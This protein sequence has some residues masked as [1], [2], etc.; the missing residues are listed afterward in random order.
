MRLLDLFCGAG[1][2]AMGYYYAG[3][4]DI[5]GVDI[6][7]QP[8]YPF[9]F[10]RADA[11]T[12]PLEEF[13]FIHA[14]PPCQGYSIMRNLPWLRDKSYPMLIEPTLERLEALGTPYALENVMGA[15]R[16]LSDAGWLCGGMFDLPLYRHRLFATNWLWHAPIHPKHKFTVRNGR[17]LGSRARDIVH[18]GAKNF[19]A[20]Y[21][22]AA[23]VKDARQAMGLLYMTRDELTQA[24]PPAYTEYIG[25]Q[26]LS[27][28]ASST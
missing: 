1:G 8:H 21:G 19:G 23:G 28:L 14:S 10:I 17:K 12:F 24:I 15:K 5:V 2:A 27:Q 22:H 3:F 7:P 9:Q 4:T 16:V 20:N 18:N 6:I 26:F 25:R 11:T 13:D